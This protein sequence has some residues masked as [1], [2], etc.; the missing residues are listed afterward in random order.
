M[1]DKVL[2]RI[3][4][5]LP[6]AGGA[7]IVY[8]NAQG[9]GAGALTD[10][11]GSA[12]VT[13]TR[14]SEGI[15]V[16]TLPGKGSLDMHC[17]LVSVD[18]AAGRDITAKVSAFSESARTVTIELIETV[19]GTATVEDLEAGEYLHFWFVINQR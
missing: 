9:A 16:L 7:T 4:A 11:E 13:S 5:L 2:G 10:H 1:L 15:Y 6:S 14:T 18:A 19:A 17:K 8:G 12:G 3:R